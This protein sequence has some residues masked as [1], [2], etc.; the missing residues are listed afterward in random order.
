MQSKD[1]LKLCEKEL[2]K[3]FE[4]H[5]DKTKKAKISSEDIY[6]VWS[7]K[8]LQNN[9]AL[10]STSIPDGMY[11]EFTFNGDKNELYMDIYKKWENKCIKL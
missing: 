9:K 3:Y 2:I 11:Y 10:L 5:S 7:C 6:I 4:E 1:F 8:S